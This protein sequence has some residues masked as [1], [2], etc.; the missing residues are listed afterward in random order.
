MNGKKAKAMRRAERLHSPLPPTVDQQ[1]ET[2]SARVEKWRQD[3]Y[4]KDPDAAKAAHGNAP[5]TLLKVPLGTDT[6]LVTVASV[7]SALRQDPGS[8]H[9]VFTSS[10]KR[11]VNLTHAILKETGPL[12]RVRLFPCQIVIAEELPDGRRVVRVLPP[13]A[14]TAED[15]MQKSHVLIMVPVNKRT[16]IV[17]GA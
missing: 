17:I 12:S 5:L 6:M 2:H 8:G 16:P 4:G 9:M 13:W 1:L 3:R 15:A 11:A 14:D 7:V 10:Y